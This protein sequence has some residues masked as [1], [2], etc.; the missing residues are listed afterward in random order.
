[1]INVKH[2][3]EQ[4]TIR[5]T[6]HVR[7]TPLERS[8]VLSDAGNCT[9]FLKLENLQVTGSFKVRGALNTLLTLAPSQADQG[10]I[11]ASTGNH[12]L[13]VAY[14]L[15][16]LGLQ[17]TIYL[18]HHASS[19]KIMMLQ[20][21]GV[22]L[23]LYGRD[24]EETEAYAR[25]ESERRGQVYISPY[26]DPH[27]IGGQGTIAAEVL[28]E[29]PAI[30]YIFVAVGGGGL[31]A[32]IAGYLK[33][34]SPQVTVVGCLPRNSPVMYESIKAGRIIRIPT[35]PTVSDGTAGGIEPGAM[36]LALFQ[37]Y[38]DEWVLVDERE[39]HQAMRLIFEHH[40][41]VVEGAAGVAI[42]AF[43]QSKAVLEGKQVVVVVCGGNIDVE[44]FKGLVF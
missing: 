8:F 3:V 9:A 25:A 36:T 35:Q 15:Q 39:I 42:A 40:R 41:L 1:M 43:L 29:L 37:H 5:L 20:R 21:Y 10:I 14:A 13:A 26:N 11:T 23:R 17:G 6:P 7:H 38:V 34:M 27:I 28:Q 30:D 19:Q 12:G 32:G 33:A 16:R 2:E 31:I 4:A 18:P 22:P 24:A 44:T